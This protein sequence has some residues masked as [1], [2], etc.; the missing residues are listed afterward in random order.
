MAL[1]GFAPFPHGFHVQTGGD[2]FITES[3]RSYYMKNF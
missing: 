2:G 3:P 1:R